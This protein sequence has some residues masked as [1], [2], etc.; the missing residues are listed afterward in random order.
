MTRE[1]PGWA[2]DLQGSL[3]EAFRLLVRGVRDRRSAFHVPTLGSVG[4]DGAPRLRSVVLRGFDARGRVLRVHTDR[5][6]AKFAEIAA[7]PRVSLHVYDAQ[8][9]VQVRISGRAALHAGDAVAAAAWAASPANC[10]MVYAIAPAPGTAVDRP[11][12]AARDTAAGEA[13]FSV[14]EIGFDRVE[15]LWLQAGGHRRAVFDWDGA[16]WAG[17][18][19]VP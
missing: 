5:R 18:W 2:D 16:A 7:D 3:A 9:A 1:R 14:L 11:P 19:L 10:R 4:A 6:S 13:D 12:D 17:R 15:W 8:A